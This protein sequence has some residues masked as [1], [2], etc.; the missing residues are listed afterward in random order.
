MLIREF[1]RSD[2][3]GCAAIYERAWN[4]ALPAAQRSI[5]PEQLEAETD[6]ERIF[7]AEEDGQVLGFASVWEPESFLHH[8]HVDPDH[9]RRGIGTALLQ[10]VAQSGPLGMSLKCQLE[11]LGALRFYAHHGF[12]ESGER[13]KDEFGEWVRLTHGNGLL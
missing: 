10:R 9:Q 3:K 5:P 12:A 11:N 8:L 7:V 6:G 13:G 1:R 4:R 2:L